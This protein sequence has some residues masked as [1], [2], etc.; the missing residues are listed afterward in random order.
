MGHVQ[1][2]CVSL[3]LLAAT[4]ILS[5]DMHISIVTVII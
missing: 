4:A 1:A 2:G 3:N 5:A